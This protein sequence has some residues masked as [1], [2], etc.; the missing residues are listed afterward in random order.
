MTQYGFYFDATRCTG[1]KTC[2]AACRD[3][4][5]LPLDL[6]YRHVYE[7]EGGTWNQATDGTWTT[8]S[9]TY[10]TSFSCCHCEKPAC[11]Q[12]CPTG[13]MH[14]DDN[15][16]VSVDTHRC[17]GCGYCE[18]ACPYGNPQVNRELHHSVKCDGC[19]ARVE[20]GKQPICVDACLMRAIQFAP[21]DTLPQEGKRANVAPLPDP[22]VTTPNFFIKTCASSQPCGSTSCVVANKTE[23]K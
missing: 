9:Y 2:E 3:Y 15:G 23:V 11:T 10:Y 8:N 20:Q 17:I 22:D 6:S 7:L 18:L 1:C 12:V 19:A 21:T 13:A 5:D 16:I 4:H 14:K